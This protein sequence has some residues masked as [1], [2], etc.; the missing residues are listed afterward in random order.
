MGLLGTPLTLL[1]GPTVAVPAPAT[2]VD[3]L[4]RVEVAHSDRGR[5]GFQ[6]VFEAGRAGASDLA[7]YP[8]LIQPLLKP[9]NRVI[10]LV[11][12]NAVPAVLMDGII[13]QQELTPSEQPGASTFTITG[14]DV[15]VMMDLNQQSVEHPAQAESVIALMLIAKYAQYGLIP[16]VIPPPAL[17]VPLP[18]ERTPVQQVTDFA[19]LNEMARRYGYVFYVTPGPAPF[20]NTAY[21]GPPNRV[22]VPQKALS[23]NL[24]PETNVTSISFH[25]DA[26]APTMVSGSVQDR[27]SNQSM[28]V[29]TFA[30]T[31]PPLV[32]Q[33]AWLVNQPNVRT[34]QLQDSGLNATQAFARAQGITDASQDNVVTASGEVDAL[35]YDG[36]L[37]PRGLVGLRGAGT[38]YD[39]AYYVQ[40]VSHSIARG[41]YKQRFTLTREGVGSL[42]PVVIP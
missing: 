30:S 37:R 18:I 28:P 5:S 34:T 6:I 9:F 1:I 15:S 11:T 36:L 35:R 7:D 22:G 26:L 33:P 19:F 2:L 10:L 8:L 38:S 29:R 4:A 25:Y 21:W 41:E 31:R 32:S 17:D 42:T 16:M 24:G 12:F 27:L 20:T 3:A 40:S 23:V 13:T 39:G 14:E